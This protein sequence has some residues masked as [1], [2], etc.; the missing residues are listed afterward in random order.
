MS[1][2]HRSC[3]SRLI[4]WG[5]PGP[6]IVG[7]LFA[8][9]SVIT[10]VSAC[11]TTEARRDRPSTITRLALSTGVGTV[12]MRLRD[13]GA[14]QEGVV[15]GD[16]VPRLRTASRRDDDAEAR[17]CGVVVARSRTRETLPFA[18]PVDTTVPVLVP[19]V[20]TGPDVQGYRVIVPG[21]NA[22]YRFEGFTTDG[23]TRVS[24]RW[25]VRS[26]GTVPGDAADADI[27]AALVP[28][29]QALDSLIIGLRRVPTT[30]SASSAATGAWRGLRLPADSVAASRAVWFAPPLPLFPAGFTAPCGDATFKVSLASAIDKPLRVLVDAGEQITAHLVTP[31]GEVTM[32]FDEQGPSAAVT[33]KTVTTALP[34]PR[35]GHVT[36]RLRYNAAEKIEPGRQTVLVRLVSTRPR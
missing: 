31:T 5:C 16:P 35:D 21:A 2:P 27:E 11:T 10:A 20:V 8:V 29:P 32:Y 36:L 23:T 33:G 6:R 19:Q 22:E 9:A 28:S 24:V 25:P 12:S 13:A 34:A 3:C 26:E 4:G 17:L 30:A 15:D 14:A 7:H 1:I 18:W